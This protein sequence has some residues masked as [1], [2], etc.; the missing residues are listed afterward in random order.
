MCT[1]VA[2][3]F[4]YKLVRIDYSRN[5]A[6]MAVLL[7]LVYPFSFFMS[8]CYTE[9]LFV[10]LCLM[11]AYYARKGMWGACGATG[12]LAALC[13]TQGIILFGVA[14]YEII[15][16]AIDKARKENKKFV[17][18]LPVS[19][20]FTLLIPMGYGIYLFINK[21]LF[22]EWTKFMEF[23]QAAPWYH[24]VHFYVENLQEHMRMAA[25][26]YPQL[27][28]VIYIPQVVMF[29]VAFALVILG[30]RQKVRTSYL[31]HIAAY[32]AI[33]YFTGWLI[34]G[35]RY[36]LGCV[37]MFIPLA[38]L[39]GKNRIWRYALTAG[40]TALSIFTL[41]LYIRGYAIM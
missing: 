19:G 14:I 8:F 9:A 5:T 25:A 17:K 33:T 11:C 13:R 41:Y 10:M 24:T 35:G 30:I 1:V 4:M 34:S 36:M 31:L 22:G 28:L 7:L 15:V 32:T 12:L 27:A 2:A 39:A 37:F 21:V 29:F 26:Y 6:A 16:Q 20:L 23:Q 38:V 3:C 40:L 18:C